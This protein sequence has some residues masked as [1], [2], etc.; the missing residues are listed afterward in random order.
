M[1]HG[2]HDVALILSGFLIGVAVAIELIV[3]HFE[4]ERRRRMTMDD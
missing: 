4:Q 1:I 2:R 3:W